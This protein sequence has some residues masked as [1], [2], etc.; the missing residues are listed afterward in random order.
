MS[1]S[2]HFQVFIQIVYLVDDHKSIVL[3]VDFCNWRYDNATEP[4]ILDEKVFY[5]N[6][7]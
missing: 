4:V 7:K 5:A 6:I 1:I 2:F 3:N